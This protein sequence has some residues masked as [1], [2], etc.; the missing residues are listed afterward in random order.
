MT[1]EALK[2]KQNIVFNAPREINDNGVDTA[3]SGT[4]LIAGSN[5]DISVDMTSTQN[6]NRM[7]TNVIAMNQGDA[8][9]QWKSEFEPSNSTGVYLGA[10][11][12]ITGTLFPINGIVVTPYDTLTTKSAFPK[13]LAPLNYPVEIAY[14]GGNPI[15]FNDLAGLGITTNKN[16]AECGTWAVS[17][18]CHEWSEVMAIAGVTASR[19]SFRYFVLELIANKF[20]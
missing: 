20:V 11:Q 9:T 1:T 14:S 2:A 8:F 15:T 3:N 7:T 13:F 18:A 17:N 16:L 4:L 10:K 5:E 6:R 12:T 19:P